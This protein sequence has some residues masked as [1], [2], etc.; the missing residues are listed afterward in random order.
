MQSELTKKKLDFIF[1]SRYKDNGFSDDDTFLTKFGNY[2]FSLVGRILFSIKIT[3]ILYTY[4]LGKTENV[5]KLNLGSDDFSFCVE[6]PIKIQRANM[7]YSCIAS[8]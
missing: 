7:K 8:H 6:L 2:F 3:D 5:K 4:V 1:A